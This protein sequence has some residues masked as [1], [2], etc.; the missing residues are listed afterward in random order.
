MH[1]LRIW[2][3]LVAIIAAA[4]LFAVARLDEEHNSCSPI[5]PILG[6]SYL[7]GL[8]GLSGARWRERRARTGLLLGLLLGPLGVILACSNPVPED[9]PGCEATCIRRVAP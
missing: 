2:H 5:S 9:W 8:L 6:L 7:C 1:G 4:T 3:I